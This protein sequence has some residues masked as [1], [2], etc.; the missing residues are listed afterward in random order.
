MVL[1]A[2][3]L[4][5]SIGAGWLWGGHIRNL[6]H[7]RLLATWLVFTAVG[8]QLVLGA[9][10]RMGGPA[11]LLSRPLLA[12]SQVLLVAFIAA[13]RYLPGMLLVL[14]GFGL[15]AIVIIA[16]GGMPVSPDALVAVGGAPAIEPGKHQLLTDA[17]TVAFLADI[18][19]VRVLRTVVS[20]GDIILAAGVG[21][22]VVGLMRRFPPLPGR[23]RRPR[24][25][26]PLSRARR[27]VGYADR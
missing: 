13:N 2:V 25:V 22:L 5:V 26:S 12:V 1:V 20:V 3:V 9:I 27:D 7:V 21:I 23:R 19:P 17:T 24:P 15:N 11:E 10:S 14:V 16:N 18:I 8:A 4:V 6:G